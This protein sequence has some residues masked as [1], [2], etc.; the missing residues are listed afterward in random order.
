MYKW[1][2]KNK[3][4][5]SKREYLGPVWPAG[6]WPANDI[7]FCS[8]LTYF[9]YS[10]IHDLALCPKRM[11]T[12]SSEK[13]MGWEL[14]SRGK[15]WKKVHT[16]L[17]AI[18][19][20]RHIGRKAS[21]MLCANGKAMLVKKMPKNKCRGSC[22]KGNMILLS[23]KKW[24]TKCKLYQNPVVILVLLIDQSS[25]RL[26]YFQERHFGSNIRGAT[27]NDKNRNFQKNWVPIK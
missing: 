6:V 24:A 25:R 16:I 20:A 7:P 14:I 18:C 13:C 4:I 17:T 1:I 10:L 15:N 19:V 23:N 2:L 5:L 8:I 12:A 26:I 11:S 27:T 22:S 9:Q 21:V 3:G